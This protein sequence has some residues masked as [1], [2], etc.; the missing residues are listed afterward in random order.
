MKTMTYVPSW[1]KKYDPWD[2]EPDFNSEG[3]PFLVGLP[4]GNNIMVCFL[5]LIIS[6]IL[7]FMISPDSLLFL[8]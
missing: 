6:N 3:T 5:F 2:L 8:T 1:E 7:F 4:S